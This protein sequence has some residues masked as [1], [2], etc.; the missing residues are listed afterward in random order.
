MM[1]IGKELMK[2]FIGEQR[3]SMLRMEKLIDSMALISYS[4][5]LK[6]KMMILRK[7]SDKVLMR[8]FMEDIR[9]LKT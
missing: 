5:I 9:I 8:V 2:L 6:N 4:S 7:P 3:S 1:K